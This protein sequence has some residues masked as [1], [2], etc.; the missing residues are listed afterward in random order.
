MIIN[1]VHCY[2]GEIPFHLMDSLKSICNNDPESNIILITDQNIKISGISVLKVKNIISEQTKTVMDMK[3]FAEESNPL[4]R[5]SIFRIFLIRDAMK[6]LNLDHCIHFDSDVLLF[7]PSRIYLKSVPEFDGMLITNHNEYEVVFG[8]SK[9]GSFEKT[10]SICNILYD[11][12]FDEDN[13]KD[14]YV[15]MPN[16]MQLLYGI[17]Q[18]RPDL[19][20][21]LPIL[22]V[23]GEQVIF[24]PSSY[25]QYFGGTHQG[26]PSG[27]AHHTHIVG[28]EIQSKNI[29]P[30]MIDKKPYVLYNQ[31]YYPIVNLHIHSKN[32]EQFL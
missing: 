19:I 17:Y 9:F 16:E 23:S 21:T 18:K 15:S 14:Y 3:L 1:Y 7:Q 11:I 26:D 25:G 6:K 8:F 13:I 10:N 22:P 2:L 12:I 31:K 4:W 30:V 29:L 28:R 5:T 24:D 20:Q 27:F 32:T